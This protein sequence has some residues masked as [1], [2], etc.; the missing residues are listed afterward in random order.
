[1]YFR[2]SFGRWRSRSAGQ[3]SHVDDPISHEVARNDVTSVLSRLCYG[4]CCLREKQAS[5]KQNKSYQKCDG[6][7][8]IIRNNVSFHRE[9]ANES[10]MIRERQSSL[11]FV[12]KNAVP[13]CVA[14]NLRPRDQRCLPWLS[15][16]L[17]GDSYVTSGAPAAVLQRKAAVMSV[18]ARVIAPV[19]S[20]LSLP[21]GAQKRQNPEDVLGFLEHGRVGQLVVVRQ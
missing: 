8:T 16:H 20:T 14:P 10:K 15:R 5:W 9:F 7:T 6:R 4:R 19:H 2:S 13:P 21:C 12:R 17:Q 1:V 11:H 3:L 18:A